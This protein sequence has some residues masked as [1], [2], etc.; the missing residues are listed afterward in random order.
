METN[1]KQDQKKR[2]PKQIAALFCV[3]LLICLYLITFIVACLD[4]PGADR[5]FP[6]CLTA[7]I[8]L[9]ILL[10]IYIRLYGMMKE[11]QAAGSDSA[12][13]LV[14]LRKSAPSISKKKQAERDNDVQ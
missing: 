11:K 12:Q 5:L 7:T 14:T 8:G 2:T 6:V 9:P 10:W 1:H 13:P 3:I 4:F